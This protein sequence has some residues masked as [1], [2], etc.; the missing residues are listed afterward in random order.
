MPADRVVTVEYVNP[1]VYRLFRLLAA[2]AERSSATINWDE[3]ADGLTDCADPDC[4]NQRCAPGM[5]GDLVCVRDIHG[6]GYCDGAED[7]A[8]STDPNV[9][10][11]KI[12]NDGNTLFDCDDPVCAGEV[13]ASFYDGVNFVDVMC[14]DVGEQSY[15]C[16]DT[17]NQF[18]LDCGNGL[19]D[20]GDGAID[21][22]DFA[23]TAGDELDCEF[24][25]CGPARTGTCSELGRCDGG[26]GRGSWF[27]VRT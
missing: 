11:D 4:L 5:T 25:L 27:S 24:Q 14:R 9:C 7:P 3:D 8:R 13:C 15:A 19:D 23:N 26:E 1:L 6:R 10:A 17:T 18:E 21:C 12:D 16:G 2:V 20:D 22:N